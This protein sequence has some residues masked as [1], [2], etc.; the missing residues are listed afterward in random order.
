M[1][2]INTRAISIVELEM[3]CVRDSGFRNRE[4]VFVESGIWTP[5][6]WNTEYKSKSRESQKQLESRIQVPLT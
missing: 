6:L 3:H 1:A 2:V 4:F 5:E